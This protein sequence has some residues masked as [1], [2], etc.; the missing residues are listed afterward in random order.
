[1]G[2]YLVINEENIVQQAINGNQIAFTRIYDE[3]FTKVYRYVYSH[4]GNQSEAEDLTQ[5]VFIKALHAI[6]SYKFKGAPFSAWL[7]RIAHNQI[8][9]YWR[10]QKKE[11]TT[12]LEEAITVADENDPVTISEQISDSEELATAL[13]QIPE[14]QGE[15][16]SLRFISGLSIAEVAET[17]GK[18]EGTIKALQFKGIASLKKI[19]PER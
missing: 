2:F 13:K 16:I 14:A 6:G 1:L 19:M 7:F 3:Y 15:V 4:V 9:D 8:I 10:K 11:K 12:T 18:R 5:D 17:L